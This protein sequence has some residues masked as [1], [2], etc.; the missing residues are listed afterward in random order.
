MKNEKVLQKVHGVIV[1]Y[2]PNLE[3]LKQCI[4]SL[5]YQCKKLHIIDNTPN[6]CLELETFKNYGNV[7]IIYLKD[8]YG[9]A[10]TQNVGIKRA[11]EENADYILLSDQDTVYPSDFVEKMLECFKEEKVAAAGPLFIDTHTGKLQFFVKKGLLGFKRIYP[12]Q[13]KHKVLQLIASGTIINA[14]YLPDIGLMMEALF[15]DWVDMEWCWRAVKKGYK[16]IGNAD[17]TILHQHG[18]DA[19]EIFSKSITLKTSLRYYYTIRNGIYLALYSDV[20][21]PYLRFLLFIKTVRNIFLFSILT[22]PVLKSLKYSLLGLCHGLIG[23]PGKLN[24]QH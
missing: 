15:I 22:K 13:G 7:E 24:E 1:T 5:V 16:I 21:N 3:L 8:N 4:E 12:K 11:L 14:K 2:K 6:G 10:Y 23:K 18:T 20:L 19:V 9:I 17:V